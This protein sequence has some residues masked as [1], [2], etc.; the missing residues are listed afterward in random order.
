MKTIRKMLAPL[1]LAA[2]VTQPAFAGVEVAGPTTDAVTAAFGASDE[3]P[4]SLAVMGDAEMAST[5]GRFALLMGVVLGI[6]AVDFA[7]MGF[8]WGVYVPYYADQTGILT[9]R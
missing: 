8:Y 3:M 4:A 1:A 5:R 7:L 2:V 9:S 6:T